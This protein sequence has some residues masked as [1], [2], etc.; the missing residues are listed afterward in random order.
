MGETGERGFVFAALAAPFAGAD[1]AALRVR[2]AVARAN[3]VLPAG[4]RAHVVCLVD[5]EGYTTVEA[6]RVRDDAAVQVSEGD[7]GNEVE[8]VARW[9]AALVGSTL[10]HARV[11]PS[12][13]SHT[14][15]RWPSLSADRAHEP[16]LLPSLR[17]FALSI[18]Y[19]RSWDLELLRLIA[20][21]VDNDGVGRER[22]AAHW[23]EHFAERAVVEPDT[24]PLVLVRDGHGLRFVCDGEDLAPHVEKAAIDAA[25]NGHATAV[26][27]GATGWFL[28]AAQGGGT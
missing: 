8:R 23:G 4:A 3:D 9:L 24:P 28:R 6:R 19:A 11:G 16:E 18:R 12:R 13:D 2:H 15:T 20:L 17:R 14:V 25:R 10:L 7:G 5:A 27:F 26:S 22:A 21:S 1:L